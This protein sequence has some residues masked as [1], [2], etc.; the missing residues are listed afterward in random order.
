MPPGPE[1]SASLP[2][3]QPHR[4][5]A[6]C[7]SIALGAHPAWR[8]RG[9]LPQGCRMATSFSSTTWSPRHWHGISPCPQAPCP[10]TLVTCYQVASMIWR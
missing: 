7:S 5:S 1:L 2:P 8:P 10:T 4:P 3:T 6:T 9:V